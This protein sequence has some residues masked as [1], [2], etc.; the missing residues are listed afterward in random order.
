MASAT[1]AQVSARYDR[2][3]RSATIVEPASEHGKQLRDVDVYVLSLYPIT[4]PTGTSTSVV[5][6]PTDEV[7]AAMKSFMPAPEEILTEDLLRSP[8]FPIALPRDV[9]ILYGFGHVPDEL[10]AALELSEV[11]SNNRSVM[12]Y[13]WFTNLLDCSH[14]TI[15]A[16][17]TTCHQTRGSPNLF[18]RQRESET[19][20]PA[21][22]TAK[23]TGNPQPGS[24]NILVAQGENQRP[25]PLV[26][27]TLNG[28]GTSQHKPHQLP[29]DAALP[30]RG[31]L[32]GNHPNAAV[33]STAS[34]GNISTRTPPHGDDT[35]KA[36]YVLQQ[37]K[38]NRFSGDLGQSIELTLRDY[39]VCSRQHRLSTTQKAD[40]FVN[41]LDG[42]ARTFF[43]NNARD[44]MQFEEMAEMMTKEFNSN[45]RQIQVYGILSKL[46][47]NSIMTEHELTSFTVGLTKIVSMIEE[48]APQCPPHFRSEPHKIG[49][50]RSA[51]LGHSWSKTPI[52]NIVTAQYSFNGFITSLREHMQLEEEIQTVSRRP[53][54]IR[55]SQPEDTFVQQ[56]G[57]NPKY[58]H[59]YPPQG[60]YRGVQSFNAGRASNSP[61]SGRTFEESG[62]RNE[63]RKC[64]AP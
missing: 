58:V 7:Q 30:A 22:G 5:A 56:Y 63:C 19:L 35:R 48:M 52:S 46:R 12:T 49:Y 38:D 57:R 24:G 9:A 51:V 16:T 21:T 14:D 54:G 59:K 13:I 8:L 17:V 26:P 2:L 32:Y 6:H 60:E 64:R 29:I 34:P 4:E 31:P 28:N 40:Y 15:R 27:T 11:E 25:L 50:L 39:N 20:D 1:R 45:A 44:D 23:S 36:N 37:F 18:T 42:P 3:K 43:F 33:R 62:R 41:L 47:I 55:H 10:S 53:T 61:S